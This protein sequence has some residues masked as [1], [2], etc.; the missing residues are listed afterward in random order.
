MADLSENQIAEESETYVIATT[1][2]RTLFWLL[3]CLALL[4]TVIRVAFPLVAMDAYASLGNTPRAYDCAVSATKIYD[5]ETAVNARISCVNYSISLMNDNKTEYA[6]AVK[7]D[8]EAFLS[9]TACMNRVKLINEYNIEN[10]DK[11]MQPNLYSYIDYISGENTRARFILGEETIFCG[12]IAINY[13]DIAK[14]INELN[15]T[16]D[17]IAVAEILDSVAVVIEECI[18]ANSPLPFNEQSVTVEAR[19]YLQKILAEVNA[20]SPELKS[21]YEIKAY[22]KYAQR[23]ISGG[24]VDGEEK[25]AIESVAYGGAETTINELY[26]NVLLNQYCK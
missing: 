18:D 9:N 11:T 3:T 26:Y 24:F 20:S 1:A 10:A 6:G 17:Y 7:A 12:G 25:S 14:L 4:F 21:L 23:L 15:K 19:V 13:T 5:G 16:N 22:Q 8:T 2:I